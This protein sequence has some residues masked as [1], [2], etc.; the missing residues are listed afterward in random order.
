M[1]SD[2]GLRP[3]LLIDVDGVLN[4]FVAGGV[5]PDGFDEYRIDGMRVLLAARHG[6][7]L[8]SLA[9]DF[10][11][12]WASTWEADANRHIGAV[13]ELPPLPHI[14]FGAAEAWDQSWTR[15]LPAVG[16]F[17]GDRPLAW[18]DDRFGADERRWADDRSARSIPTLL[19][20]TDGTV[21]FTENEV[22]ILRDFASH[23]GSSEQ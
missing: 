9:V 1:T 23:F 2:G 15:K 4:P 19:V 3:L 21:G 20:Q 17:A 18:I 12:V 13:L 22:S 11:L 8:R 14:A 5:V 16:A 7:W 6:D 10:E